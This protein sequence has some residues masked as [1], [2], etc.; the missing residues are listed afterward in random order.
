MNLKS[1]TVNLFQYIIQERVGS[2]LMQEYCCDTVAHYRDAVGLL[3][4]YWV[5]VLALLPN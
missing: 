1:E 4:V 5:S 3:L 2:G